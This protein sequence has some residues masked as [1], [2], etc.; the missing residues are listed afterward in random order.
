[1]SFDFKKFAQKIHEE[2]KESLTKEEVDD[3]LNLN[4]EYNKDTPV[5]TG[6]RLIIHNVSIVGEKESSPNQNYSGDKIDFSLP[7]KSGVNILIAD[8]LKGKSSVFKVIKYALTGKNSL[9][10]N[11][12]KWIHHAFV[13]FYIN[14][15]EY[16]VYLDLTRR[17]M[18]ACLLNGFISSIE[19]LETYSK[20]IIF[21]A[22]SESS[23]QEYMNDF[24]FNQFTYY[25]LK[26]TQ[27]SSQKDNLELLEAGASWRTYFKS[28]LLESKDSDSL[29]YGSQG[30]KVF[31]MLL[32]IELTYPINRLSIKKDM[33]NFD[34]AK[35]Q[36]Y[37]EGQKKK[38]ESN[39]LKLQN[40]LK[41][42]KGEIV[43]IQTKSKQK[44][45]LA[46]VYNE[47]NS[48]LKLINS[49][50]KK[51]QEIA[52]NRQGKNKELNIVKNKQS[53]NKEEIF[54]LNKEL[55]KSIKQLNN[56][57]EY[58]EI[59]VLFSNLDI[60]HCPSCNHDVTESHKLASIKEHKC[61]LCG[62]GI[63]NEN[64]EV[65]T[66]VYDEKIANLELTV[67]NIEKE[68]EKLEKQKEKLQESFTTCYNQI[69]SLG[70]AEDTVKDTSSLSSRLEELEEIMNSSKNEVVPDE[71][72]KEKLIAEQA[73]VQ[74]QINE[75][76]NNKPKAI[77]DYDTKIQLLNSA[78][79]KLSE[80]RLSIGSRVINRLS[81]LMT[82]EIQALG[83][84]SITDIEIDDNFEI[85]YKQDG[86]FITFDNIAEGEQLRAKIAFYLSLIQLDIEFNF[87][88]HTRLLIIDSPS[89]EEADK[90][91]LD[92]LSQVLNSIESRYSDNLQILIGTAERQLSG[93]LENEKEIPVGEYVF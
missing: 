4:D 28:I 27:K 35:E 70:Q 16:T 60:K 86:E 14:D 3:L 9:K 17:S 15:K 89:K 69:V 77:T 58:V 54:R 10:P 53:T 88:R 76:L 50:N 31:Q 78:I 7:L 25:S 91:Y 38:A 67:K 73:V 52:T 90:E 37:S 26:W 32:G 29:M 44:V 49:E 36:S 19:D 56:L 92:G 75:L 65:D 84:N 59:G 20:E 43:D 57:K 5:S 71:N 68:L 8:N 47:Y 18:S 11:I 22:N 12:K 1:M 23:F 85:Q 6:K 42:I 64:S 41:A 93:I 55:E 87:G 83:L 72:K 45:N 61:S 13:N 74:F 24:I 2:Y 46:P 34:K 62:D 80:E 48:T 81:K 79:E 40:R 33:L 51:A 63:E 82:K 21:E 39:L 66:E 30:K